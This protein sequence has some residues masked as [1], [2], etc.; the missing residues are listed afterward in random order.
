MAFQVHACSHL[1]QRAAFK[2]HST[3][4]NFTL[5]L[6]DSAM[7]PCSMPQR[8]LSEGSILLVLQSP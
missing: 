1:H 5:V 4:A 2:A 7:G 8:L 6:H 3:T